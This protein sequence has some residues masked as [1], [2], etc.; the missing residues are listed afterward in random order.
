[1]KTLLILRHA[2]AIGKDE[3]VEDF[4]RGLNDRGKRDAPQVGKLL[5][6]QSL[7]PD[8]IVASSAKRTRKTAEYVAAAS[9]FRGETRLTLELYDA[10]RQK[11]L[12]AVRGL[13][14]SASRVLLVGHNPGLEVLLETLT[15]HRQ[16]LVTS[17]L[18]EVVL[19]IDNWRD[20]ADDR[21][22]NLRNLWQP[23]ELD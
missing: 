12:D 17:A 18:A 13:P 22:A 20:V 23:G 11:L 6:K 3:G 1:M 16:M 15:G 14:D 4:D 10:G 8:L 9:D 7:V 19:P 21:S 5:K 2:K